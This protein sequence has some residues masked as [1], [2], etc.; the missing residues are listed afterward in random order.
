M[1]GKGTAIVVVAAHKDYG[2]LP[3]RH[4]CGKLCHREGT[5]L[6][7]D[8]IAV[9]AAEDQKI[10]IFFSEEACSRDGHVD[11]GMGISRI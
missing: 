5:I 10:E 7:V 1:L 3:V 9:V 8:R 2:H 4:L 6:I 11:V